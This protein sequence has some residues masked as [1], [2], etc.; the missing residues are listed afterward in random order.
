MSRI[1][2]ILNGMSEADAVAEALRQMLERDPEDATLTVNRDAA[3]RRR[4]DLAGELGQVL[5][6]GQVDLLRYRV[7]Q[8]DG[9]DA[10]ALGVARSVVLFQTL[11]TAVLDGIRSGPKRTYQPSAENVRLSTLHFAKAPAGSE[12][13]HFVIANDR[14]LAMESEL[15]IAFDVMFELVEARAKTLI[16]DIA[17]R[18]GIAAVAA[19]HA[20][21]GNAVER[22]L[23]T[24]IG[25]RKRNSE[26]RSV[27]LSHSEA[28]LFRKAIDAVADDSAEPQTLECEILSL[29][30]TARS[31]RIVLADRSVV[32]GQIADGFPFGGRWTMRHW[33]LAD[34]LRATRVQYATGEETV[35]W[36]L[37]GL[38][39][40]D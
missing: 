1:A 10:P 18:A 16:R 31:F 21:A 7:E 38:R 32:A 14:L 15:D 39:P 19:A 27:T 30:E 11:L 9:S 6:T 28:L 23:T 12:A 2:G 33:Y 26:R 3:L 29:D 5:A 34:L 36:S 13:I 24:T 25:W 22:G 35:R 40:V 17:G 4:A 8:F 37:R 20:W